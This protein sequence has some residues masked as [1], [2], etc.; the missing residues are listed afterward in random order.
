MD[1]ASLSVQL[2][3]LHIVGDYITNSY[4]VQLCQ[5]EDLSLYQPTTAQEYLYHMVQVFLSCDI[6]HLW[7]H[8][9]SPV[10]LHST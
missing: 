4:S 5:V 9:M 8:L 6:S 2:L 3:I 10:E 1:P 7:N